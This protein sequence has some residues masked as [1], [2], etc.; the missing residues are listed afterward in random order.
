MKKKFFTVGMLALSLVF[1]I[2]F[3][4]CD[5][6]CDGSCWVSFDKDGSREGDYVYSNCV[7]YD[8]SNTCKVVKEWT[9][10]GKNKSY[11]CDCK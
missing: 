9:N 7:D 2:M 4:S 1:G 6:K 11:K 10:G 3:V 5:I 8:C